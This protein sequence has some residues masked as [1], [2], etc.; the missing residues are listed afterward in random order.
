MLRVGEQLHTCNAIQAP[1]ITMEYVDGVRPSHVWYGEG[2]KEG[3]VFR[4]GED[5]TGNTMLDYCPISAPTE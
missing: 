2:P 3:G 5:E 1:C 4:T